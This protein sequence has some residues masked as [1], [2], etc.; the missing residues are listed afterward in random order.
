V[1]TILIVSLALGVYVL[2][3]VPA[4]SQKPQESSSSDAHIT[5]YLTITPN[6]DGVNDHLTFHYTGSSP[7][8]V[9]VFNRSGKVLLDEGDYRGDWPS[10]DVTAE[11]LPEGVYFFRVTLLNTDGLEVQDYVG[12]FT[13]LR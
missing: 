4:F 8:C 9:E 7:L 13:V 10:K 1:K 3:A 6:G 5:I 2:A 11:Q 12:D